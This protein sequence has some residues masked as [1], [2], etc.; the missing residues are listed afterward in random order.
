MGLNTLFWF[1]IKFGLTFCCYREVE[2]QLTQHYNRVGWQCRSP[3]EEMMGQ[4]NKRSKQLSSP[5][6]SLLV[7]PPLLAQVFDVCG[8]IFEDV[9]RT[10]PSRR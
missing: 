7:V 5:K 3:E 9:S 8:V 4:A 6:P 2:K 1:P 10:R